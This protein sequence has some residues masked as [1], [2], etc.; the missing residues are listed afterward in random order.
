MEKFSN[1]N[2]SVTPPASTGNSQ[3]QSPHLYPFALVPLGELQNH[4][5][6][7]CVEQEVRRLPELVQEWHAAQ[8]TVAAV[9]QADA[10]AKVA[11]TNVVEPLPESVKPRLEEI[12][13]HPA[14]ARTFGLVRT[15]FEVVG[16]DNLVGD[17]THG[18]RGA[19]GNSGETTA[20]N[21]DF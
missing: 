6:L 21:A 16:I 19:H 1:L 3:H 17:A 11:D 15:T 10:E 13:R 5:R 4:V 2:D 7:Q 20:G 14:F 12:T 8:Q 9:M 18:E